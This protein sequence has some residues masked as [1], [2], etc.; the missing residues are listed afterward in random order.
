M[1]S[2]RRVYQSGESGGAQFLVDGLWP[3][4]IRKDQLRLAGW[5]KELAPSG[6]LRRWFGH[7]LER[8]EEFKRRYFAELDGKGEA[9]KP[10]LAAARQGDVA[11]LYAARDEQHNNAA[12]LKSYLENK[13]K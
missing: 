1:I 6:E 7:R 10:L 5:L 8:W 13:L 3:R 12:A 4:G 11:L 9:L 2:I